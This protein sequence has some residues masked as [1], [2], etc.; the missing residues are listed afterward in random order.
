MVTAMVVQKNAQNE[1]AQQNYEK[2]LNLF[3]DFAPARKQLAILDAQNPAT[4]PKAFALAMKALDSFPNDP[5]LTKVLGILSYQQGDYAQAE[6][7]LQ[8]AAETMSQD[9]EILYYLGAA[10]FHLK[11]RVESKTA[12]ERALELNL[13][14][15]QAS[16]AKKLLA[17]L[18]WSRVGIIYSSVGHHEWENY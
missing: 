7:F 15:Q 11:N 1:I 2:I 17:E 16:N 14:G 3:P 12:L 10:Q 18:K 5:E 13:S 9:A 4:A 8:T 6:N